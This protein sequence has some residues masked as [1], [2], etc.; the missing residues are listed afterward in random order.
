MAIP[1][2]P[3]KAPAAVTST[4]K[5]G[6]LQSWGSMRPKP[7]SSQ[8]LA[9]SFFLCFTAG[10]LHV[11]SDNLVFFSSDISTSDTNVPT[12]VST[13]RSSSSP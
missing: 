5:G 13:P 6:G 1:R 7:Y 8:L 12:H 11:A 4:D 3:K 9:F 10:C 2:F